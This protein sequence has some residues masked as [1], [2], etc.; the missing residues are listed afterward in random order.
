MRIFVVESPNPI[1]LLEERAEH[2]AIE[3]I[4]QLFGHQVHS[5]LVKSF[6]AAEETFN[7]ISD[8]DSNSKTEPLC[9][10]ISTH[11][12][13]DGLAF[14]KD[15]IS[16]SKL[17]T[18]IE[19]I[20]HS[21]WYMGPK[22]LVISACGTHEQ[23]IT[24]EIKWR[25]NDKAFSPFDYL[26]LFNEETIVWSDAVL[27]WTMLY[28]HLS[29]VNWRKKTE[30]SQIKEIIKKINKFGIGNLTYYRWDNEKS[31]YKNFGKE[32]NL[33]TSR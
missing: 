28:H 26:F 5:F 2:Q 3:K 6:S 4:G 31:L 7:Y 16:W 19:P 23:K 30:V 17:V 9:I 32:K 22:I 25:K 29:K 11:G 14:G 24:K 21:T 8:I 20:I 13:E 15:E 12:D 1:D 18:L 10:H 27:A 33:I